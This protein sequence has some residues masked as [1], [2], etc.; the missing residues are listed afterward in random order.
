MYVSASRSHVEGDGVGVLVGG[1]G[2]GVA[3]F[4]GLAVGVAVDCV[5]STALSA[6]GGLWGLLVALL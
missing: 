4:A 5:V 6:V 1:F 3:V 2:V